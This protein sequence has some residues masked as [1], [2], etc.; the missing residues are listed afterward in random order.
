MANNKKPPSSSVKPPEKKEPP[1]P[2]KPGSKAPISGQ[3]AEQKQGK[4]TGTEVTSTKGNRLPPPPNGGKGVT[5]TPVDPTKNGS[6][7]PGKKK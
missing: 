3:F 1:K 7:Q 5:Y 2:L 4:Q 6:G